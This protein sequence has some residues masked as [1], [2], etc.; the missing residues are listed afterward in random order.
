MTAKDKKLLTIAAAVLIVIAIIVVG[1]K[2]T[3]TKFQEANAKKAELKTQKV[4]MK[5]EIEALPSYEIEYDAAA[6]SYKETANRIYGDLNNQKIQDAVVGELVTA[7][8]L[9]IS[10]FRISDVSK[11]QI[12]PYAIK[13]DGTGKNVG[14]GV[15][16]TDGAA[17]RV[18][19]ITATVF[20]TQEQVQMLIDRMDADEGICLQ[21]FSYAPTPDGTTCT[22]T[23]LMVLSENY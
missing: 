21:Q 19:N 17:V 10:N 12:T 8:G 22:I 7:S 11:L 9:S 14:S 5:K 20:G 13:D 15:T 18:A 23:F 16:T 1:I 6:T 2:P 4:E 3:F